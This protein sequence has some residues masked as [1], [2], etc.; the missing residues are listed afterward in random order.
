MGAGERR[1][2]AGQAGE[3]AE[4]RRR[5][6][7]REWMRRGG[8]RVAWWAHAQEGEGDSRTSA[9]VA[10]APTG[11]AAGGGKRMSGRSRARA[12]CAIANDR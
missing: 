1:G 10:G 4:E 6:T 12:G 7:G 5:E 8:P 3:Q 2:G 9:A 11:G